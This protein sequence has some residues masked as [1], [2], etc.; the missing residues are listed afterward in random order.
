LSNH[1]EVRVNG[2]NVGNVSI[3]VYKSGIRL[4]TGE[5][6]IVVPLSKIEELVTEIQL[7]VEEYGEVV[8]HINQRGSKDGM[9]NT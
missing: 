4:T 5:N 2:Y 6:S 9:E 3:E 8:S 1:I 7:A